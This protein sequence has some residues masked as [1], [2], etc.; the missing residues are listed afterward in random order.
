MDDGDPSYYE[1][2]TKSTQQI[3]TYW[4]NSQY[5]SFSLDKMYSSVVDNWHFR[6]GDLVLPFCFAFGI[7]GNSSIKYNLIKIYK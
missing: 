4:Q 2:V 1:L 6:L 7:Y 5:D 3:Y